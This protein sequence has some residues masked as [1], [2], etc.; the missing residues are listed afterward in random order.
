MK[1]CQELKHAGQADA[2]AGAEGC[3]G[4]CAGTVPVHSTDN[5][6]FIYFVVA[7]VHVHHHV[8]TLL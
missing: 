5:V 8:L 6:E 3:T 7:Y 1:S 4:A 2:H